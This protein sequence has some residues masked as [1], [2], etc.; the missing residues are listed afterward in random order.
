MNKH[1]EKAMELR[2]REPMLYN[3]SQAIMCAYAQE[4][5]ISEEAAYGIGS[6]FGAGMKCGGVCGAITSGLMVL[7]ALGVTSPAV[8]NEFRKR[9]A[10][11]HEG[12][13]N[14]AD[15]L[16]ANAARGGDKKSH[17]DGMICEA[18]KLIDELA[19]NDR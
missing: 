4:L 1:I 12:N 3:C 14:C 10:D 19:E 2:N 7:G 11:N 8:I 6:N 5:G 13:I 18:I 17:C 15:L 9:I 16:R